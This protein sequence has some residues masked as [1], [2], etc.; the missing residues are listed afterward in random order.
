[1]GYGR[2]TAALV[3]KGRHGDPPAVVK[4]ADHVEQRRADTVEKV[5][6][7]SLRAGHLLDRPVLDAGVME[8]DQNVGQPC[9]R[10]GFR[11][12]AA[13]HEHPIG[14][15]G[16]R[17]PDF[18]AGDDDLVAVNDAT[19]LDR[20]Q[21]RAVIRLG[22]ALA[23]N[24]VSGDDPRE[25]VRLLLGRAVHDDGRPDQSLAH[26]AADSR[27]ART[28]ELLVE[29]GQADGIHVLP[30]A[31]LR[32]LR[33]NEPPGSELGFPLSVGGVV[34][35]RDHSGAAPGAAGGGHIPV[36]HPG[37]RF[38]RL[39]SDPVPQLGAELRDLRAKV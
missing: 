24:V 4:A 19:G 8:V 26:P 2:A 10:S 25:E 5:L 7:E 12:G 38:R 32:P 39:G 30:A 17:G 29:Y 6:A 23:V 27:H 36:E 20:G 33:A 15:G 34:Q 22:K 13:Q 28:A 35:R 3:A 18:L 1:M 37:Q 16:A 9:V 31:V 21:V 14:A 11:I